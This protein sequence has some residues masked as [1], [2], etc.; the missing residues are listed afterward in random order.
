MDFLKAVECVGL[1][2]SCR[3]DSEERDRG[4]QGFI[5]RIR[6]GRLHSSSAPLW[7]EPQGCDPHI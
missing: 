1:I 4:L 6:T 2:L 7:G 3:E 5:R